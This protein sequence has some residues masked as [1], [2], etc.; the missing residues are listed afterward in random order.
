MPRE[1]A[2]SPCLSLTDL[3]LA[4]LPLVGG[5]FMSPAVEEDIGGRAGDLALLCQ[6][7]LTVI[8]TVPPGRKICSVKKVRVMTNSNNN[9][10]FL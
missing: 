8:K 2:L 6:A 10:T 1:A 7:D 3:Q 5:G 4:G 9:N